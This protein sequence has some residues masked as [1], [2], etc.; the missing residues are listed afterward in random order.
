MRHVLQITT[1]L[2]LFCFSELSFAILPPFYQST[3]EIIAILESPEVAKKLASPYPI[4]S[5]SKTN[6]GYTIFI[7][8]CQLE[9]KV[10]YIPLEKGMVGPA[11]FEIEPQEKVC[12]KKTDKKTEGTERLE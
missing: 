6:T 10:I 1:A 7:E 12:Q 3:K 11:K 4:N 9:V 2:F 8:D 5:I